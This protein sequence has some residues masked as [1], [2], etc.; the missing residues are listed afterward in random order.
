MMHGFETRG[1][2]VPRGRFGTTGR[3]GRMFPELRSFRDFDPAAFGRVGGPMDGGSPPPADTS[4]NNPRIKAGYTFLGQFIDHDL[5]LDTTSVLEQQVDVEATHNFRTPAFELDSLYGL[6]PAVQPYIYDLSKP[7]RF[8]LSNNGNDLPRNSDGRALIGDPRNDENIIVSQLHLLMLKFHNKVFETE[9]PPDA[10]VNQARFEATQRIVRW[11]YQWLILNEFLPRICGTNLVRR[12]VSNPTFQ[13][14]DV[15]FMPVEFSVAAYRFGHS[16]TRPGYGINSQ[17][18][19]LLFPADPTDITSQTLRGF[20]PVPDNLVVDW[21]RFFGPV[22][23]DSKKIDTLLS[24]S[25]LR[26]PDGVV[27]PQT[28]DNRRSLAIRNLQR[29]I[30]VSL[31]SGQDVA[32][33]LSIRNPLT[34]QEIWTSNGQPMSS[35]PAPLW[36]YCLREGE[37]RASG[38]RLSGVGA[39]IVAQTFIALMLADKASYLAQMPNWKPTLG[40][41]GRFTA[42]D[43]VNYTLGLSNDQTLPS[44]DLAS[45]DGDDTADA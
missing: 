4:Q 17:G 41:N 29:G 15:P 33:A 31:P 5:T 2:F 38:R 24:T 13:F 11:H 32:A 35:G 12:M 16:Q 30:D 27:P 18:G 22:A 7:F 1:L 19:A 6:G 37:V 9:F 42:S 23:Q 28:P 34:E 10:P 26:L 45:L 3:F 8:L 39:V 36:F 25:M 21:A 40:K 20:R 14:P 44:E 43:L